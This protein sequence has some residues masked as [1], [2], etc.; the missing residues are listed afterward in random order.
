MSNAWERNLAVPF[1]SQRE[2][3][4]VWQQVDKETNLAIPDSPKISMA[5]RS[6]NIT[7]LCMVLHFHGVTEETPDDMMKNIFA[8][9]GW[10]KVPDDEDNHLGA[11][12]F[13]EWNNIKTA[14]D[15]YL[16]KGL[17]SVERKW[18]TLKEIKDEIA[19]GYPVMLSCGLASGVTV[20][21]VYEQ[22]GHIIVIRGFTDNNEIIVNDP[23]GTPVNLERNIRTGK[24]YTA[25]Y[26]FESNS[27]GT[28]D[29]C[30]INLSEFK[31]VFTDGASSALFIHSP[32]WCFPVSGLKPEDKD[33]CTCMYSMEKDISNCYPVKANNMWHDGIHLES[34]DCF[35]SIGAGRLVA[36]RN[37]YE[38][39]PETGSNSFALVQYQYPPESQGAGFKPFYALYMHLEPV[40]LKTELK[41]FICTGHLTKPLPWL[42]RLFSVLLPVYKIMGT[43]QGDHIG[44]I[45][46][47]YTE[48]YRAQMGDDYVL[49]PTTENIGY[50]G[51]R[52]KANLLPANRMDLLRKI[53]DIT[54][55]ADMPSLREMETYRNDIFVKND[56]LYFH[57]GQ[58]EE[59]QLC[60]CSSGNFESYPELNDARYRY[61]G[62][63]IYQLY[64][65]KVVTFF[66]R[67]K[68]SSSVSFDFKQ[69]LQNDVQLLSVPKN[70]EYESLSLHPFSWFV[71]NK[72]FP[73]YSGFLLGV[74]EMGI[75]LCESCA[76]TSICA[77]KVKEITGNEK[78]YIK[79][80]KE[81]LSAYLGVLE[82]ANAAG[83]FD[84]LFTQ[85]A[86]A[87]S[88]EWLVQLCWRTEA[89]IVLN[90]TFSKRGTYSTGKTY[91]EN[92]NELYSVLDLFS[93][94]QCVGMA[95]TCLEY[96]A[97]RLMM[98]PKDKM[99]KQDPFLTK[100][101]SI[102]CLLENYEKALEKTFRIFT[103][104][105]N[106]RYIDN[107]IELPKNEL[108]GYGSTVYSEGAGKHLR[109]TIHFEL[110]SKERLLT[111]SSFYLVE[112]KDRNK[113][114]DPETI[115]KI[116]LDS[117][118]I[119]DA[120]KKKY[121]KYTDDTILTQEELTAY[122]QNTTQFKNAVSHHISEWADINFSDDDRKHCYAE[123]GYTSLRDGKKEQKSIAIK[124]FI[125][126]EY[127]AFT[128]FDNTVFPD[129][130]FSDMM[131]YFYHPT[132]FLEYVSNK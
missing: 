27:A 92:I 23:Y 8:A 37:N 7:S 131:A 63:K 78:D 65:N 103:D 126:D 80:R 68:T 102:K 76:D 108:I 33:D 67:E 94:S 1:F 106:P 41:H 85:S 55:Y 113:F 48:I 18:P 89:K 128:W 34:S 101:N 122:Y 119:P 38:Q 86:V 75:E 100:D 43:I 32:L 99:L 97:I 62:K 82:K 81:A 56:M 66:D 115:T 15:L 120:D 30:I 24:Q 117:G 28:G 39:Q 83:I 118:V 3:T 96:L 35:R 116:L 84:T 104:R 10:D 111:D 47:I 95:E 90:Y 70:A 130:E 124:E 109:N 127:K 44:I 59:R 46:G 132:R 16:P 21:N 107:Y 72:I 125:D 105:M 93:S 53:C 87:D 114:Y 6:C 123:K 77:R 98:I 71:N 60:C 2:N 61:Y 50:K 20:A 13:E 129:K 45:G 29:N 91:T 9:E 69:A 31:K 42:T 88:R 112:N 11:S 110:F 121:F 57:Y 54:S 17:T 74:L 4:Y 36:L 64:S 5:W 12:S 49:R 14:A 58:G 19:A 25:G 52:I 26:Y 22:S 73:R 79:K 51:R 40:D